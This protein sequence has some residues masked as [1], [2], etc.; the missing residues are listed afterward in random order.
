AMLL[1]LYSYE[2]PQAHELSDS[3]SICT[4][5]TIMQHL[6]VAADR[7]D[8]A[9]LKLMCEAKLCEELTADTVADTLA[10]A[11]QHQCLQLKAV[12][13]NFAAKPENFG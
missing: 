1:F 11:E 6:L 5:I 2:L 8:L 4:S 13:L 3:D 10:V 7:F 12:C 9:R